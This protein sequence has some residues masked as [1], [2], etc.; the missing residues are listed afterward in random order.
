M[1]LGAKR[2][3]EVAVHSTVAGRSGQQ[4]AHQPLPRLFREGDTDPGSPP[5]LCWGL[6]LLCSPPG[7]SWITSRKGPLT[8]RLCFAVL[9]LLRSASPFAGLWGEQ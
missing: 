7:G 9:K 8:T 4:V 3:R 2:L 1:H 5:A 6:S